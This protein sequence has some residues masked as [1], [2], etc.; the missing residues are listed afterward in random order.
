MFRQHRL[1]VCPL[2]LVLLSD[3]SQVVASFTVGSKL[4]EVV[5]AEEHGWGLAAIALDAK[6]RLGLQK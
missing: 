1:Y 6:Q 5:A 4:T 3:P 2:R